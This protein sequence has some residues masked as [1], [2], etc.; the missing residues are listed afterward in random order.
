MILKKPVR[1]IGPDSSVL[2][3]REFIAERGVPL[4]MERDRNRARR[5]SLLTARGRYLSPI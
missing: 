4:L 1:M 3:R 5:T 2:M